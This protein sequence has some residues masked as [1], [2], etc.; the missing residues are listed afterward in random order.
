[1]LEVAETAGVARTAEVLRSGVPLARA[2]DVRSTDRIAVVNSADVAV[3]AEIEVLARW[4]AGKSDPS[5]PI[6]WLLVTFAAS[7]GASAT[8][9][10]R[11]VVDGSKTNPAP[12]TAITLTQSGNRVTVDTGVA[13]FVIDGASNALFQEV[14]AGSTIVAGAKPIDGTVENRPVRH[15]TLRRVAIEHQGPL[16]AIVVVEGAYD[17]P[18]TGGGGLGSRLRYQFTAGSPTALVRH[19]IAFEGDKCGAGNLSCAAGPNGLLVARLEDGV[20]LMLPA[21]RTVTTIGARSG[22]PAAGNG[23]IGAQAWVRQKLRNSRTE[24]RA[25]DVSA[26]SVEQQGVGADGGLL[27]VSGGGNTVA[28]ALDHMQ[29]MEPQAVRLKS[30]GSLAI[31]VVDDKAWIGARQGIFA[32]YAFTAVTGVSTRADLERLTWAPLNAP[33]RA[34]PTN[35]MFSA[36]RAVGDLPNGRLP[37]ALEGYDAL[38]R[39]VNDDTIALRA[40]RGIFGVSVF[41]SVPRY[42]G[43][44]QTTEELDC[45]NDPTP[46][47]TWDNLYWCGTFTDYHN[48]MNQSALRAMRT[49]EVR[50]LDEIQEPAALRVLHTQILQCAPGDDLFYCGQSPAGYGGFRADMNSSHAYFQNLMTYYWLTG[51]K[52]VVETI[53]RGAASM[54]NYLCSRRPA[55]ACSPTDPPADVWAGLTDRVASQWFN[56]FRFVGLASDDASYLDDYRQNLGRALTQNYLEGVKDGVRY[57]FWTAARVTGAGSYSTGQLWMTSIYDMEMLNWLAIDTNDAPAG[58]PAIP[59]SRALAAWARTLAAYA[60]TVMGDGT[61]TAVMPNALTV[62]TSGSRLD[63]A[64]VSVA[65][66]TGGGDPTLYEGGK[67]ALTGV[68]ARNGHTALATGMAINAIAAADRAATPIGKEQGIFLAQLGP[69]IARLT[70]PAPLPTST[71]AQSPAPSP[72]PTMDTLLALTALSAGSPGV[73]HALPAAQ[74]TAL[75]KKGEISF[76]I[77][78]SFGAGDPDDEQH[79][80]VVIGDL[81]NPPALYVAESDALSVTYIDASWVTHRVSTGWRAPVFAAKT[82]TQI[83]ARWDSTASDSMQLLVNGARVDAGGAGVYTT[84]AARKSVVTI[85]ADSQGAHGASALIDDLLVKSH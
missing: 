51:D 43:S 54:R 8:S 64:L 69:A 35:K 47:D 70:R 13:R 3:P 14:R 53:Q 4:N 75:L 29:Y 32:T 38:T 21:S 66:N 31:G 34:W 10:Y 37:D 59:P 82:W 56:A 19:S 79:T 16:S 42:W 50:Y 1:M 80:F 62:V 63:G 28:I 46:G 2:F 85:G 24:P 7:A 58:S 20:A 65:P 78:P 71:V 72:L 30:D 33:L 41:G 57:G 39:R 68:L 74:T 11:L 84:S 6:Q 61:A 18:A 44:T 27:A 12:P 5:A 40:E 15:S 49:G 26:G 81:A 67:A 77:K 48:G 17:F 73:T 25:F 83:T 9:T 52:T 22:E 60:P 55:T 45:G 36:S 76:R 23:S